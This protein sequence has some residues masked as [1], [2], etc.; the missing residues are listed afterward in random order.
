[1]TASPSANSELRF[2]V[3]PMS[4]IGCHQT[5]RDGV[6]DAMTRF[7]FF[8]AIAV[9]GVCAL[10]ALTGCGGNTYGPTGKITGRLTLEGRPMASGHAVSFMQM[11]KG[12]L[13]FGITDADG[14]FVV[15][16]WNNGD[17]PTG[18][19]KVMIAPPPARH[20]A[21]Q[22]SA[23][24]RFEHPELVDPVIKIEFPEK[25]RDATTSG[26]EFEVEAGPNEFE[27][28]LKKD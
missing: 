19:Y 7:H 6:L 26:I 21:N 16:S 17:M 2:R 8:S 22:L 13:A 14:D 10:A 28:D 12:F 15:N 25:Y 3:S 23:E 27:I 18:K 11:E 5:A 1:M 24:D 4:G 20:D 9:F